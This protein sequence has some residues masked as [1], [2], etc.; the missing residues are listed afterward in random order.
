MTSSSR[1][2]MHHATKASSR[3]AVLALGL[4]AIAFTSLG[5]TCSDAAGNGDATSQPVVET[6]SGQVVGVREGNQEADGDSV[7]YA[8]RGIP[9]AA[10]TS[11]GNRWRPPQD[12]QPWSEP[13]SAS[14][15]GPKCPQQTDDIYG[16]VVTNLTQHAAGDASDFTYPMSEDCLVLNVYSPSLN[17]TAKAPVMVYIH[18]GA[19]VSGTG[20]HYPYQGIVR[21]DVVLV[22][23]NY[24][25]GFLG[26]F[27]HPSLDATNFGLLDQIKALEWVQ[28]NIEKFGGDPAKVTI[29]GQSSGGTA[30]MALMVSP[31]SR[32]LFQG[33]IS[34]SGVIQQSL[35]V[36]MT[37]GGRLGVAVGEALDI[38]SGA[39]QLEKLRSLPAEKLTP[40]SEGLRDLA[41]FYLFVDGKSMDASILQK[42]VNRKYHKVPVIFGTNANEMASIEA[43]AAADAAM[44]QQ[45]Q[46]N[47]SIFEDFHYFPKTVDEYER[48]VRN[49]FKEK[50]YRMFSIFPAQTD[51]EALKAAIQIKTDIVY[52]LPAFLLTKIV[53]ENGGKSYLYL[54]N[55]KPGGLAGEKIGAF[56]GSELPYV[57]NS[58]QAYNED[59]VNSIANQ[60]L[61][62]TMNTYW[63]NFARWG[64]PN[65]DEL[66]DE[67]T[68]SL[69]KWTGAK[70][71]PKCLYATRASSKS[72]WNVLGPKVGIEVIPWFKE[73][74][75]MLS[76]P[77]LLNM[78][79]GVGTWFD[80]Q[81]NA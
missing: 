3:R 48:A 10:D 62:N 69:P 33:A 24:R 80:N 38:P 54:F 5:F 7:V 34:E 32:G 72:R 43:M 71:C 18:G 65:G 52:G 8:F 12:P 28:G 76:E 42:F 75:Y 4:A 64:N 46:S 30:V 61:A 53:A 63:T 68:E 13:R 67:A 1:R 57:F 70:T 49:T 25:L 26:Y 79:S 20:N 77:C 11:G 51:A 45:L 47:E 74:S 9:Y 60:E 44:Q 29:F 35:N 6:Q 14:E 78:I 15:W 17:E 16:G 21:K 39:G 37:E 66:V 19:L 55:Q 27:A 31:L 58:T 2:M 36:N 56:H 73:E 40:A 22:T 81:E 50:A 23:I 59:F 41:E